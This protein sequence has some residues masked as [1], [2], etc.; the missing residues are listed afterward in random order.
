M[1]MRIFIRIVVS[2]L[3]LTRFCCKGKF[4]ILNIYLLY[5]IIYVHFDRLKIA[6]ALFGLI[7]PGA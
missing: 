3:H 6:L 4:I 7:F 5:S 1:I 2:L